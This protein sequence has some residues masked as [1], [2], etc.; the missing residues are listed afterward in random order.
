MTAGGASTPEIR[1]PVRT[2][3]SPSCRNS[4]GCDSRNPPIQL[5]VAM[6]GGTTKVVGARSSVSNVKKLSPGST[7]SPPAW[8]SPRTGSESGAAA[9][10]RSPM[11]KGDE[12]SGLQLYLD[13]KSAIAVR[14]SSSGF[15]GADPG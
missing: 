12:P 3:S 5:G 6:Y 2:A 9:V 7:H 14:N 4:S 11:P 1:T 8:V 10:L 13:S 15:S